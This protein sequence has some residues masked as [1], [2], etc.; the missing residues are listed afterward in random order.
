M[1]LLF[2]WHSARQQLQQG[3]IV[4]FPQVCPSLS[5]R[6]QQLAPNPPRRCWVRA[7]GLFVTRRGG[8]GHPSFA[9]HPCSSL[10]PY[11]K[12]HHPH[13]SQHLTA[14]QTSQIKLKSPSPGGDTPRGVDPPAASPPLPQCPPR[15]TS[16]LHLPFSSRH[17]HLRASL[18]SRRYD[19]Y[20]GFRSYCE[21]LKDVK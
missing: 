16:S 17:H 8:R 18:R 21:V 5:P 2:L 10:P 7:Q 20:Y 11:P 14:P 9:A 12:Q 1:V 3:K 4:N 19:R 15:P 6:C 13:T